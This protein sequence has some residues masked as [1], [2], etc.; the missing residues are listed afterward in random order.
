MKIV[1]AIGLALCCAASDAHEIACPKFY[2]W[3][4]TVLAEV[5]YRHSGKGVVKKQELSGAVWMGGD[6]NDTFGAMKA[7]V[8]RVPGGEDIPMPK[9]AKW[10]VCTYGN[11]VAWWEQLPSELAAADCT[12][13]IRNKRGREPMDAKLVCKAQR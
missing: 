5:P 10:F 8:R 9:F 1:L 7:E 3:E 11:G 2:P 4:D 13:Q 6:F 12:I